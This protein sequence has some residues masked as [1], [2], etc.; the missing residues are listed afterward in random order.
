MIE[1]KRPWFEKTINNS[2]SK[3]L[4]YLKAELR[5]IKFTIALRL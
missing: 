1:S 3:L 5:K 4:N 2:D